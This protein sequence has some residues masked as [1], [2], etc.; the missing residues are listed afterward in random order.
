MFDAAIGTGK[1]EY[2]RTNKVID[3][4]KLGIKRDRIG[5]INLYPLSQVLRIFGLK[6]NYNSNTDNKFFENG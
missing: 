4:A 3:T 1:W 2:Q 5:F 6:Q